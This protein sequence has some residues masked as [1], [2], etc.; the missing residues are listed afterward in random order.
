MSQP[1][2]FVSFASRDVAFTRRLLARLRAQPIQLWDYS[3]EG[4]EIP[5]GVC[6]VDYLRQ[7]I[8]GADVVVP[9][10]SP[11]SFISAYAPREVERALD[12][13][14]KGILRV[15]PVRLR[16]CVWPVSMGVA[17]AD[18]LNEVWPAP[19]A[20]L[21]ALRFF[22]ASVGFF[23]EGEKCD[24][25]VRLAP[26]I[27]ENT[28]RKI[29]AEECESLERLLADLCRALGVGYV[30]L[31]VGDPRLPLLQR[32]EAELDGSV[33]KEAH[34]LHEEHARTIYAKICDIRAELGSRLAGGDFEGALTCISYFIA[35]SE[36][37]L[38]QC[39]F[40]YP[41]IVKAV[42]LMAGGQLQVALDVLQ[43]LQSHHLADE[44]LF[45]ALGVI[46]HLM[47][48]YA[49]A[50]HWYQRAD[51]TA[52]DRGEIDLAAKHGVL[53]NALL[54]G[55]TIDVDTLLG[56]IRIA[57]IPQKEDRLKVQAL[58]AFAY[59][60]LGRIGEAM[61]VYRE[62]LTQGDPDADVVM[63]FADL[64]CR[65][66]APGSGLDE[67]VC[68]L[69]R[70]EARFGQIGRYRD[71]LVMLSRLC[72]DRE[73]ALRHGRLLLFEQPAHRGYWAHVAQ[74]NYESGDTAEAARLAREILNVTRFGLPS[75]PDD[76]Y[77]TG[78]ANWLLG[79][80]DRARYDFE[81]SGHPSADD[82]DRVLVPC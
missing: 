77:C 32:F 81:R 45:S 78:L 23:S 47:G 65:R 33:G 7:R 54:C 34:L 13:H 18:P 29:A 74:V 46:H 22:E 30:P 2:V 11:N 8:Q 79:R 17:P 43:P 72:G 71:R 55:A 37:E 3:R 9:I 20:Q 26:I 21:C 58:K 52:S 16:R 49:D 60:R 75:S 61:R 66:D 73:R 19:Y 40:Y 69:E 27:A 68:L 70:Y 4:E 38:S 5:A 44:S 42:C 57:E 64:L 53:Y 51:K 63:S 59:A 76:F 35:L 36:Y 28:L 25:L 6:L 67:A 15:I 1:R 48:H 62:I 10:I 24:A 12:L 50:F 82:Y 41:Y 56:Q 14:K 39:H 31:Y 80:S